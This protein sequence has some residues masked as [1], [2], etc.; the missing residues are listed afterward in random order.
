MRA[1]GGGVRVRFS[2][3][4]QNFPILN[5]QILLSVGGL[6]QP[7]RLVRPVAIAALRELLR[8]QLN[9]RLR[10]VEFGKDVSE[11][12]HLVSCE[13]VIRH[14]LSPPDHDH[15][16]RISDNRAAIVTAENKFIGKFS[17]VEGANVRAD[18]ADDG[19]EGRAS[20]MF[21]SHKVSAIT[22][23]LTT[24]LHHTPLD[25]INNPDIIPATRRGDGFK[26]ARIGAVSL[27]CSLTDAKVCETGPLAGVRT[28]SGLTS[29][30]DNDLTWSYLLSAFLTL[31][32]SVIET[33]FAGFDS[34]AFSRLKEYSLWKR[35][36]LKD[37]CLSFIY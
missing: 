9:V 16:R 15:E 14:A 17:A 19:C 4:L 34:H 26:P 13:I 27:R 18:A 31:I 37:T 8:S 32:L 1:C 7:G 10:L 6:R 2:S 36:T 23:H 11:L 33:P 30:I 20:E 5:Q 21:S 12:G 29:S 3:L 22:Y 28:V 35:K 25:M 24:I